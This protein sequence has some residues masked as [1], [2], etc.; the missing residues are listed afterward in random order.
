MKFSL[1]QRVLGA[2]LVILLLFLGMTGVVL[3]RSFSASVLTALHRQLASTLYL[4]LAVAEPDAKGHIRISGVLPDPA[5]QLP[6]SGWLAWIVTPNQELEWQSPSAV[7]HVYEASPWLKTGQ[8]R[9]S[10]SMGREGKPRYRIA[11]AVAWEVTTGPSLRRLV[12]VENNGASLAQQ[13]NAFRKTL[14]TSLLVGAGLLLLV[15]A[16]ILR[17]GLYP[18]RLAVQELAAVEAGQRKRLRTDYP[19]ELAELTN[20]INA[21]LDAAEQRLL[22]R[23]HALADLAH[24]LKTPLAVLRQWLDGSAA[25]QQ[26]RMPGEQLE[27]M[28]RMI[29]YQLQRAGTEGLQP[30]YAGLEIKPILE[31]LGRALHKVY[32]SKEIEFTLHV[33]DGLLF[34]GEYGD[35]MELMGNLLDNAFKYGNHQVWVAGCL[36]DA[37]EKHRLQ[38]TI[39]DDGTGVSSA[40]ARALSRRGARADPQVEGQGIG[41]AVVSTI[42]QA[43]RGTLDISS[44]S[45]GGTVVCI[46]IPC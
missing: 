33:A 28:D 5:L 6:Q 8:Q 17:W 10:T 38:L 4:V 14:W 42:I 32:L 9:F 36:L 24:S 7:G 39:T 41:L 43:Y 44:R 46:E 23:R 3:E 34:P 13:R 16:V 26:D 25:A 30:V 15:M 35:C 19:R 45:T 22:R 12:V 27:R 29:Q 2:A 37:T 1:H 21:L 11:M 40:R 18:L 31:R 20:R